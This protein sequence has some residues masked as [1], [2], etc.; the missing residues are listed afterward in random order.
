[1]EIMLVILVVIILYVVWYFKI[2]YQ[3][4]S[5]EKAIVKRCYE[6]HRESMRPR[7]ELIVHLSGMI[8]DLRHDFE[9]WKEKVNGLEEAI[10]A[11]DT[12][13][14]KMS[15]ELLKMNDLNQRLNSLEWHV[16]N[17]NALHPVRVEPTVT[18]KPY[19]PLNP[20]QIMYDTNSKPIEE[21]L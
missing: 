12:V 21:Q 6:A 5:I 19:D 10:H 3:L 18:D 15:D 7:D 8:D 11:T 14:S 9:E 16:G 13:A 17:L 20:S 2:N 1:M 4:D